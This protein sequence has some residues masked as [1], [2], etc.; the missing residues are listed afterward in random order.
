VVKDKFPAFSRGFFAD[1]YAGEKAWYPEWAA[2]ALMGVG[3][4]LMVN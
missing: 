1:L 4:D 2:E 3:I